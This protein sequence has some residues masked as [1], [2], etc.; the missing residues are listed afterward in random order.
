MIGKV[1]PA[2]LEQLVIDRTG[3]I[4]DRLLQGA[5]YGEDTAAIQLSDT[6]LVVNTDPISLAVERLGTLAVSVAS[7]DIAASGAVPEWMTNVLFL[8]DS[9]ES[10]LDTITQQLDR[11]ANAIDVTIIGGH[12]EYLPVLNTPLLVSTCFGVT[13]RY[14]PTGGAKPGDTV[15]LTKGAGIEGTAILSTDFRT[16]LASSVGTQ[17]LDT[18]ETYYDKLSILPEATICRDVATAMHDPTEGGVLSGLFELAVASNV[19]L[20]IDR[21][22]I[23]VSQTTIA[24]CSAMDIDP[25]AIFGSGGLLATVPESEAN[26]LIADLHRADIEAA[27]IGTVHSGA[28]TL[29]LDGEV[30]KEPPRD[31]MYD[32]WE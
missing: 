8:P 29:V 2:L 21:G 1:D 10:I 12:T 18:G 30:I 5:A 22:A 6:I 24:L 25:L 16:Q 26:R 7:N 9:N 17:H 14:V 32:L 4:D 19:R 13:D 3:A 23:P 28:P 27:K 20:D 31:A 15:L 11:A